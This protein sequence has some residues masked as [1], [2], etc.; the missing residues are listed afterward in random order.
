[1]SNL[2]NEI[3][4][5]PL[6]LNELSNKVRMSSVTHEFDTDI[7]TLF[8]ATGDFNY[9]GQWQEGVKA[10]EEV[11]HFLPRVGMR[12][13]CIMNDGQSTVYTTG[14]SYS[15]ERIVFSEI[16]ENKK[17]A[18]YYTLEEAAGNRSRLTIDYYL[19]KNIPAQILFSVL[20]KN[21]WKATMEKSMTNLEG[22]VKVIQFAR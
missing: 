19:R 15:P 20:K 2:K 16:D 5:E 17:S 4:P 12:C 7:I 3:R 8:H 22:L 14:Y 18:W 11:S 13:R 10:V 1:L 21:K 6:L 9:R